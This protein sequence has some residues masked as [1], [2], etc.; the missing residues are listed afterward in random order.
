M[1]KRIQ[2]F[3]TPIPNS[4]RHKLTD[5]AP[6]TTSRHATYPFPIA[7]LPSRIAKPLANVASNKT[8][9]K[10]I[11]N[12]PH[13]DLLY[14][15]PLI[16]APLARDLFQVLRDELPFYRVAYTICR[17]A[18]PTQIATPRYTTV[19]GVDDT[20]QFVADPDADPVS[21]VLVNRTSDRPIPSTQYQRTPRPLP[22]CLNAL[23]QCVEAAT[24][25]ATRYNFC[26]VNY[27][28]SGDDSIA[29]HSDDERFLGANPTIA[30][31]SLG[32]S[33]DFLLKHKP[34]GA[35]MQR[36]QGEEEQQEDLEGPPLK[37]QLAPGDLLVMRGE[38]QANWLHSI[39]KRRGSQQGRINIT[40]RRAVVPAGTDNYYRYNV[41]DGP[42]YRWSREAGE[43]RK[44]E[45]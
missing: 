41:G 14:F 36:K 42:V 27:Y 33:R 38:T 10:Q 13:L 18:T 5:E 31:L 29:Y 35:Q 24:S 2:S 28:A 43:M 19:F 22:A 6:L 1:S 12:K 34:V 20:A 23:R 26:L 25:D 15:Q 44:T 9:P 4:K 17:G 40:F 32:A 16:P 30:S 45:G 7:D 3:F 8:P 37:F 21:Q 39:P 11:A